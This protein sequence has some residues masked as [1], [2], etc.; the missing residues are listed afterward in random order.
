MSPSI[1][2]SSIRTRPLFTY[3]RGTLYIT[4]VFDLTNNIINRSPRVIE[5]DF[6][7]TP[8]VRLRPVPCFGRPIQ[9]HDHGYFSP[10]NRTSD[11]YCGFKHFDFFPA[12]PRPSSSRVVTLADR[13]NDVTFTF[14]VSNYVFGICKP[15][16]G[17]VVSLVSSPPRPLVST[18][19]DHREQTDKI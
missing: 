8:N 6:F 1:R 16:R 3:E 12:I 7:D 18:G 5:F 19:V 10:T 4:L 9:Q 17:R 2:Y 11:A 15:R 13:L 14:S